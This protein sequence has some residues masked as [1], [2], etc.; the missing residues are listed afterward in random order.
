MSKTPKLIPPL[1]KGFEEVVSA[2][3]KFAPKKK[4][5][6]RKKKNSLTKPT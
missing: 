4:R 6:P 5:P 2:V 1:H 3:A